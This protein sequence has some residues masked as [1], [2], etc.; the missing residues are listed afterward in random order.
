MV[1]TKKKEMNKE[2]YKSFI[3]AMID[4]ELS[5]KDLAKMLGCS[6][7]FVFYLL[8]GIRKSRKKEQKLCEILGIEYKDAL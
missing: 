7:V 1:L 8:T 4:K 2:R 6:D 5:Q 3:M